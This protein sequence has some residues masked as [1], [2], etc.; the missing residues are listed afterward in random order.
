MTTLTFRGSQ[1]SYQPTRIHTPINKSQAMK[2]RGQT[3]E[4]HEPIASA[5]APQGLK[6]RG[7]AY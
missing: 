4:M 1:V 6:Y 3:V 7:I 5:A 2:Y